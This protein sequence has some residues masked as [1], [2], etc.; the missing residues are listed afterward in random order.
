M[1]FVDKLKRD[2]YV[3][4]STWH[5][6]I[7]WNHPELDGNEHAVERTLADPD[8]RTRDKDH[9]DREIFYRG[10][11]LGSPY[12]Q[13]LLKVVVAFSLSPSGMLQGRI[14]TAYAIDRVP[15][16]EKRLWTKPRFKMP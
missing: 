7:V 10:G 9:K 15:S 3:D 11:V 2:I 5:N 6:K 8:V 1:Q 13:D 14:V 12:Q 4:L 16:T